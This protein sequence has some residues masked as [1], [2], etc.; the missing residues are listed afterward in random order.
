MWWLC[1]RQRRRALVLAPGTGDGRCWRRAPAT[2]AGG[3]GGERWW[4]R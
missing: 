3:G 1:G 4:L 2:T